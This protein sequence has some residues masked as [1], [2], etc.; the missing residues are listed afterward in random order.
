[1]G[2]IPYEV[3]GLSLPLNVGGG[4]PKSIGEMVFWKKYPVGYHPSVITQD[5]TGFW[6]SEPQGNHFKHVFRNRSYP[7]QSR[8]GSLFQLSCLMSLQQ[9]FVYSNG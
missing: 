1:M 2:C 9:L 8:E 5:L 3:V 7:Y 4:G 6:Q